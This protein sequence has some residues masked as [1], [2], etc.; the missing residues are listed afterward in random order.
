MLKI[1]SYNCNSVRKNSENVKNLLNA[2]DIV[3]LQELLLSRSDLP[4]LNDFDENFNNIALVEDRETEGINEGRPSRGVAI[5]WRKCFTSSVTPILIDDRVIGLCLNSDTVKILLLNVY[6]PCDKQN[7]EAIHEYR[8]ALANL[9]CIINEQNI[10]HV[11]LIG[12]FNADPFK[13]RFWDELKRFTNEMSLMILNEEL[14]S[15]TF[16]YLCPAKNT[17]SWLDHVV[18]SRH[19][20]DNIS[21]LDVNYNGAIYDHFP[22]SFE[23]KLNFQNVKVNSSSL[24]ISD[25]VDWRKI[26]DKQKLDIMRKIDEMVEA[27]NLFDCDAFYCSVVNCKDSKHHRQI[28]NVFMSMK[29]ILVESTSQYC[30]DKIQKFKP[31][32]GW[33]E[34]V[35]AYYAEAR[36]AFLN[37]KDNGK[38]PE[39]ILIEQMKATR[40]KF[41]SALDCCRSNEEKIRN[42]NLVKNLN[43]KKYK[44]FWNDLSKSKNCNNNCLNVIDNI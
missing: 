9:K 13:G 10:D 7:L 40:S 6:L 36:K 8:S 19:I 31:V 42:D 38:P 15:D 18:C 29:A 28:C 24:Y 12:D 14:P 17:T 39:G 1:A 41:R 25:F 3:C 44:E 11:L 37:W 16:T 35:K 27:K 33:N 30:F 43:N 34:Y 21:N 5:F 4:V 20:A 2:N 23:L 32:P 22:L 26:S